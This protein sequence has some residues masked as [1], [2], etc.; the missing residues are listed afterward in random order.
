MCG[1]AVVRITCVLGV[2]HHQAVV[3]GYLE[4]AHSSHQ[5]RAAKVNDNNLFHISEPHLYILYMKIK[6]ISSVK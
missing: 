4:T 2:F 1:H 6:C 3:L 5:F